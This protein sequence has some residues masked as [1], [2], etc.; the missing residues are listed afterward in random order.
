MIYSFFLNKPTIQSQNQILSLLEKEVKVIYQSKQIASY[1][2][3]D[4]FDWRL[5]NRG[6]F[7]YVSDKNLV[8]FDYKGYKIVRSDSHALLVK[9]DALVLSRKMEKVV[10]P[11]VGIRALLYVATYQRNK[12]VYRL[13]NPD[14][15]TIAHLSIIQN[16]IKTQKGFTRLNPWFEFQPLKGYDKN[17]KSI[18]KTI[19][20]KKIISISTNILDQGRKV[21][22]NVPGSYSS[23]FQIILTPQLPADKAL[24]SIY[25]HLL[26]IMRQNE[27]GIIH[28]YDTEFL[29]DF[30]VAIRRTRSG[31][32]QL[33]NILDQENSLKARQ[34]FAFLGQ[35]TNNLRDTDVYL[36]NE[37]V[38]RKMLPVHLQKNLDAFF[39]A[40]K[41][42]RAKEHR[43]LVNL[44]RSKKYRLIINNWERF[45]KNE[46]SSEIKPRISHTPII[47]IAREA[48]W[49]RNQ[50]IVKFGREIV[51]NSSDEL[52]HKL[53]IEAK[54]LRYLLEFFN[55][56]FPQKRIQT[57]I[58]NLKQLQ[59][60][61]GE[62]NDLVI[63]QSSL[64]NFS[65]SLPVETEP[66]RDTILTLGILIG[67]L[68]EKEKIVKKAF[69]KKFNLYIDQNIQKI[70]NELFRVKNRGIK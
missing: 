13:L 48:I 65:E 22:K 23:K 14:E 26:Q 31:L 62:F 53:R 52:L 67:K 16:K 68:H 38:Y 20:P 33:K 3:Y 66:G 39:L 6:L 15:K 11:I 32:S 12:Q 60:N 36:L 45:L 37:S 8:L 43:V 44:I 47:E 42:G 17:V 51:T 4:T 25:L 58:Q 41:D 28:D 61:L 29:H 7:L 34:E 49:K 70:Y 54:K 57:L 24:R 18:L 35:A 9:K 19:P 59:D 5:Y 50:R 27:N 69:I 1:I 46:T 64:K 40:L 55:S 63:Q 2:Y 56:L 10:S 30:R 21:L